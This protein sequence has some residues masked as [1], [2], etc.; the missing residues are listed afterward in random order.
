MNKKYCKSKTILGS[1]QTTWHHMNVKLPWKILRLRRWER[2]WP[3]WT[4]KRRSIRWKCGCRNAG[5]LGQTKWVG[6]QRWARSN[7]WHWKWQS[8]RMTWKENV[9][10]PT[11]SLANE[12]LQ[13]KSRRWGRRRWGP[14]GSRHSSNWWTT[15]NR[16]SVRNIK[17]VIRIIISNVR[18]KITLP[19]PRSKRHVKRPPERLGNTKIFG[20]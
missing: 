19:V 1:Y 4:S 15:P 14:R 9:D 2:I 12:I 20:W 18:N 5:A 13:P 3:R 17:L 8:P 6:V 7:W 11:G 16:W 10:D